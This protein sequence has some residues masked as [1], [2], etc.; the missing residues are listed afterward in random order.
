[1]EHKKDDLVQFEHVGRILHGTV[2]EV[3]DGKVRIRTH[4]N[5]YYRIPESEVQ[6]EGT[7]Q[8]TIIN[9]QSTTD[10]MAKKKTAPAKKAA[11]PKKQSVAPTVVVPPTNGSGS[12]VDT[13]AIKALTCK[14]Y[15]KLILL[16]AAGCT[17][18]EIMEA[19]GANAG[20]VANAR[21]FF[22]TAPEKVAEAKALL[23]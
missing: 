18:E 3:K 23:K 20:E 21:K 9:Q 5:Y 4:D 2:T 15:Q 16:I 12:G 10:T 7:Q 1:M 19:G 6:L 11:A 14:K 13:K 8:S 22:T 17:K